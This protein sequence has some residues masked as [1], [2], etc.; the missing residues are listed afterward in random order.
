MSNFTG[1]WR[2][3][4]LCAAAALLLSAPAPAQ[5]PV[6]KAAQ[7][8]KSD[9]EP[10]AGKEE[11]PKADLT[12]Q[13]DRA[14]GKA[15]KYLLK[16]Q[17]ADGSWDSLGS[18]ALAGLTLLEAGVPPDDEAIRKAATFVR[19]RSIQ[20]GYQYAIAL[21]IMFLDRLGDP[22]DEPFIETL[23]VRLLGG[24]IRHGA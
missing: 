14:V 17:K 13:V 24:Q 15:V 7:E 3:S 6:K 20:D 2:R 5:E 22:Q 21:T 11:A 18:T 4:A 16:L 23:A 19:K 10:A 1:C 9:K 12:K 8:T